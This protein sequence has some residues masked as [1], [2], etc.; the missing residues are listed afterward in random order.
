MQHIALQLALPPLSSSSPY[1]HFLAVFVE[2][3][4]WICTVLVQAHEIDR[5]I[6]GEWTDRQTDRLA[7][8]RMERLSGSIWSSS[9]FLLFSSCLSLFSSLLFLA[10]PMLSYYS[11][12]THR[13]FH[14]AN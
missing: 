2:Q 13:L 7:D 5:H 1:Y 8:I 11:Y 3:I 6:E 14:L 4:A 12:N 10:S 9:L